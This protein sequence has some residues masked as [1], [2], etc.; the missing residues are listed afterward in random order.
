MFKKQVVINLGG[1]YMKYIS[2]VAS[3]ILF[4]SAMANAAGVRQRGRLISVSETRY[5]QDPYIAICAKYDK[6][7]FLK[8]ERDLM[9]KAGAS[10]PLATRVS[11]F[12]YESFCTSYP[13]TDFESNYRTYIVSARFDCFSNLYL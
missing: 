4:T 12:K 7:V 10:C 9:T 8:L 11:E 6:N 1:L 3:L 13:Y 5:Q 2:I